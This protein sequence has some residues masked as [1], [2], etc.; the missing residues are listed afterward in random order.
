MDVA[1][2]GPGNTYPWLTSLV[3]P[4]PIAWVASRSADGVDNLAPH[5][6]FT[7]ASSEPPVLQFT[8]VGHKDSLRNVLDTG[9]FTVSLAT[10]AL[11]LQVNATAT[12]FPAGVSEFDACGVERAPSMR[13]APPR[14]AAS[15]VAFECVLAGTYDLGTCAVVFGRVVH[16]SVDEDVIRDGRARVELLQPVSRLGGAEWAGVGEVFRLRRVPYRELVKQREL[17]AKEDQ[18]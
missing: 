5:S 13:V 3:L 18:T 6:F 11:R 15:P 10:Y 1:D 7:V 8:S 12:D 16:L 2:L 14:V 9:E 17:S 4:R